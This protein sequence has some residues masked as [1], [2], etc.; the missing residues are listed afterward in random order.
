MVLALHIRQRRKAVTLSNENH[1]V[2]RGLKRSKY[3]SDSSTLIRTGSSL[4]C[5]FR[6]CVDIFGLK[7]RRPPVYTQAATK[8]RQAGLLQL[9][10]LAVLQAFGGP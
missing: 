5:S 1:L 9:E 2:A 6:R 10:R 3:D 8:K 7:V 4:V